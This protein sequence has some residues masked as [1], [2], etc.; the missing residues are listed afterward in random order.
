MTTFVHSVPP[1]ASSASAGVKVPRRFTRPGVHPF[2]EIAWD[3]RKTVIANPDGSVVF[4]MD[5]VEVPW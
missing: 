1:V 5:A 2:D 4:K 3:H